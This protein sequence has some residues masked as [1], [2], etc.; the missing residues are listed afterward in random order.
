MNKRR[1]FRTMPPGQVETEVRVWA[2]E[3]P[4][5]DLIVAMAVIEAELDQRQGREKY[6]PQA[7]LPAWLN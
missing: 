5:D 2:S 6:R 1:Y 3:L 4:L 7:L